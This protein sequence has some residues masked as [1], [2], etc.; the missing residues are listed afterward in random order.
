MSFSVPRAA[1]AAAV[2][3]SRALRWRNSVISRAR[4]SSSTATKVS[5]APGTPDRPRISTGSEGSAP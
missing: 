2:T 1:P 4:V 5:P 3:F